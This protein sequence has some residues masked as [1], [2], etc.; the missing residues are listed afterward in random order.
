MGKDKASIAPDA[1]SQPD[2]LALGILVILASVTAMAFA[3]AMVKLVS[4]DMTLWQVFVARSL[5]ALPCLAGIALAGG[6]GLLPRVP[7]WTLARSVLLILTWLLFYTSL[8]V[9]DLAI[10]ATAVYTNPILTA[11]FSALLLSERVSG[12]QWV[13]IGIGFAGVATIL[14]PGGDDFSPAVL[15][16]LA[17]AAAYS[18]AM[19]VTRSKC[20]EED[21]VSLAATLHLGFILTGAAAILILAIAAPGPEVTSFYPFLL[22][23]WS[24]MGWR[25]WGLMAFLG[26]LSAAYFL[27]V[28]FAYQ[29]APPAIIG[30]FDYGYLV[31]AALWGVLM[32]AEDLS[33]ATMAGMALITFA[34]LMVAA[35][36]RK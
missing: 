27:G 18:L 22:D 32:F 21:P 4:S 15:L 35:P 14:R 34:G 19:V 36:G 9:L 6:R 31:F 11:L 16:P 3:D 28:A 8:P 5:F 2:R 25:E 26:I 33:L 20:R 7:G 24:A 30:T 23:P 10:A 12:R 17:A 29:I 1:S 13:G